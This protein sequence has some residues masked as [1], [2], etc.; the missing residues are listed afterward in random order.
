MKLPIVILGPVGAALAAFAWTDVAFAEETSPMVAA[1]YATESASPHEGRSDQSANG[2]IGAGVFILASSYLTAT[3]VAESS[4]L[5]AD[6]QMFVPVA[7][8][9]LDLARRPICNANT[10]GTEFANRALIATDGLLQGLGAFM[11]LVG[12]L[13][14]DDDTQETRAAKL[15]REKTVHVS[16]SQFGSAG[17]GVAAYGRF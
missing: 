10:C 3:V 17:Y 2:L 6:Q 9:W 16:P 8:P 1:P 5:K 4:D 15:Q 7:G 12:L 11:T 13:T 14:L